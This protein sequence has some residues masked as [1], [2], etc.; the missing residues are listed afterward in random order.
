MRRLA[1]CTRLALVTRLLEELAAQASAQLPDLTGLFS[2][3]GLQ[4]TL[5]L[6]NTL[7]GLGLAGLGLLANLGLGGLGGNGALA[8]RFPA[9]R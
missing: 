7:L 8:G 3:V 1:S 2:L 4:G 5:S 6:A 9:R